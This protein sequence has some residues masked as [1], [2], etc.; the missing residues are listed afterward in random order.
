MRKTTPHRETVVSEMQGF[1]SNPCR[2]I[3]L[4]DHSC[5]QARETD[6]G[7]LCS[8]VFTSFLEFYNPLPVTPRFCSSI[9]DCCDAHARHS[10]SF[11]RPE[12]AFIS[13]SN[14]SILIMNRKN[15]SC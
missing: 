8:P 6:S 14:K 13:L 10:D 3:C 12:R 4:Q 15:M 9:S 5:E 2:Q 11:V 1:M 7:C